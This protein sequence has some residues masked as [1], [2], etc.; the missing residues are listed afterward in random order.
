MYPTVSILIVNMMLQ[1]TS[2]RNNSHPLMLCEE[3]MRCHKK[4]K[5]KYK[6]TDVIIVGSGISGL[7]TARSLGDHSYIVI[8]A[9]SQN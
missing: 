9:Q 3:L 1:H 8:E 4:L 7:S 5:D 6:K 2:K